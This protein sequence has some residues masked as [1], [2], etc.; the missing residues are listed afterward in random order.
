M[1]INIYNACYQAETRLPLQILMSSRVDMFIFISVVAVTLL[2]IFEQKSLLSSLNIIYFYCSVLFRPQGCTVTTFQSSRL[3]HQ[4]VCEFRPVE[5]QY[6][7]HGC[8]VV[9]AVKVGHLSHLISVSNN[10]INI[11]ILQDIPWHHKHCE[12]AQIVNLSNTTNN[13][14]IPDMPTRKKSSMKLK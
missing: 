3:S 10:D 4:T 5:C 2:D 6:S 11:F 14:E 12:Y 9:L 7:G 1:I 13:T 8:Q